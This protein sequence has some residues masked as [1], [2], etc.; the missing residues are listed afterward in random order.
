MKN[1]II[2]S[3][4]LAMLFFAG[5]ASAL[6]LD[7]ASCGPPTVKI[8]LTATLWDVM[9]HQDVYVRVQ[10]NNGSWTLSHPITASWPL[11]FPYTFDFSG[12]PIPEFQSFT[13]FTPQTTL[14]IASCISI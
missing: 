13:V 7:D 2:S 6:T 9:T 5:N 10:G 12:T 14:G 1:R 11:S 3:L 4:L 8:K